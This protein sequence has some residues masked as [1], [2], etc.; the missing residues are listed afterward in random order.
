MYTTLHTPRTPSPDLVLECRRWLTE[1]RILLENDI[2]ELIRNHAEEVP[3]SAPCDAALSG[4]SE[5]NLRRDITCA[6]DIALG[7]Q[8]LACRITA[9]ALREF[10]Y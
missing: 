4:R 7:K 8:T 10:E 2:L 9:G 5:R 6:L 3:P 1:K